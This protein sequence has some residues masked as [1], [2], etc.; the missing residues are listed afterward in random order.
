[1]YRHRLPSEGLNYI[2]LQL[3]LIVCLLKLSLGLVYIQMSHI[4]EVVWF[5]SDNIFKDR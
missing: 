4:H 3:A 2:T 5:V 1:M